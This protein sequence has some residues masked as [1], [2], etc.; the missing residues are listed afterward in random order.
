LLRAPNAIYAAGAGRLLGHRFLALHHQGRRTGRHRTAVLEVLSWDGSSHEAVVI[1]GL[2]RHANWLRN[3]RAAG[4]AEIEIGGE[5][6]AAGVREL[7]PAEGAAL[8]AD[9]ERRNRLALPLVR[10]LLSRLA[11]VRYDGSE[12]A[13]RELVTRLPL[14]AFSPAR[15]SGSG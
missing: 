4:T 12:A 9:F 15:S 8:L 3:V 2:G 6:W 11:D 7:G 13:R 5:R 14:I 10:R 1:S